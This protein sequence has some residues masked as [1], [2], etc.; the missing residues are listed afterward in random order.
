MESDHE[1]EVSDLPT[2][3]HR[4][5][6]LCPECGD[7]VRVSDVL[8]FL[9]GLHERVCRELESVNGGGE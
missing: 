3:T 6:V 9:L 2:G 5:E 4:V 8:A 1:P 7:A